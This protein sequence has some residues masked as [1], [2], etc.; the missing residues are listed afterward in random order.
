MWI[1]GWGKNDPSKV[2]RISCVILPSSFTIA[3]FFQPRTLT[4][5]QTHTWMSRSSFTNLPH[6]NGSSN[7]VIRRCEF[8]FGS[9]ASLW[10]RYERSASVPLR[11][12]TEKCSTKIPILT[13]ATLSAPG[14]ALVAWNLRG[15]WPFLGLQINFRSM[16]I[17]SK[18]YNAGKAK[19]IKR[20]EKNNSG[21][22]T[23]KHASPF[24]LAWKFV[25]TQVGHRSKK[26]PNETY[27]W[28]M[29]LTQARPAG[30]VLR[31][32]PAGAAASPR[33]CKGG[34]FLQFFVKIKLSNYFAGLYSFAGRMHLKNFLSGWLVF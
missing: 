21:L 34:K 32:R 33:V 14:L 15:W 28:A 11:A 22:P 17:P 23:Q 13:H 20:K 1:V 2:I 6:L 10:G 30:N 24:A 19:E 8:G 25:G 18:W 3:H 4:R 7:K 26:G 27:P 16:T 12:P 9:T 5:P 29:R 31:A